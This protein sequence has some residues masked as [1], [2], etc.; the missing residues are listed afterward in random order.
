MT[1]Q[2]LSFRSFIHALKLALAWEH[3]FFH[4]QASIAKKWNSDLEGVLNVAI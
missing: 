4:N 3:D 1:V 2:K